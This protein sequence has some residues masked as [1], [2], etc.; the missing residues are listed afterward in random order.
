MDVWEANSISTA[1][2]PHPCDNS[3]QVMCEG[4]ACG[5]TY[6]D[7]R[8][9]G[10]CDPDG[11]DFNSYRMGDTSFYGPSKT[12]DTTQ[13]FTV[14]T[15]FIGEPLTEIK[16][17][18]VQNGVVIPNSQSK[19]S[20]V[21]GNSITSDFCD[22]QKQA[23]GDNNVFDSHGG[24]EAMG[25]ALAGGMT[26]V[27]SVWD[28]HYANMLWL[29]SENYPVNSTGLGSARGTCATT[30][31][32][33]SDIESANAD[34]SVTFSNIKFGPINSTFTSGSSS[35]SASGA[36]SSVAASS[37]AA[38]SVVASSVVAANAVASS[39]SAQVAASTVAAS[40][41]ANV[42]TSAS[43]PASTA[44]SSDADDEDC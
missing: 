2:T 37:V 40:S 27:M 38:S 8:Y 34:A 42:A 31:G 36:A 29:D 26:L 11:C 39:S 21:T 30:S 12:V 28:D 6:S 20:N 1:Y 3:S 7:T 9:A 4:D 32:V 24:L 33:P 14:V 22:A 18:Y 43:S 17:F 15:Q 44:G 13:P 19:I 35:S 16:R 25:T 23:F 5:G 41:A 10:T